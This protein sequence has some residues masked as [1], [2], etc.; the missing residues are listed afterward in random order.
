MLCL[1]IVLG[2]C[3]CV[4]FEQACNVFL[5][6]TVAVCSSSRGETAG[7]L[8]WFQ[9]RECVSLSVWLTPVWPVL[10]VVTVCVQQA[11]QMPGAMLGYGSGPLTRS[12]VRPS[13]PHPTPMRSAKPCPAQHRRDSMQGKFCH[14]RKIKITSCFYRTLRNPIENVFR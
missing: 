2:I 4:V 7:C 14:H 9:D 12:H 3:V 13:V 6:V 1:C 10:F 5:F 8:W 11:R